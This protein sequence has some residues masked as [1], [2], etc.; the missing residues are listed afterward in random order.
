MSANATGEPHCLQRLDIVP[1]LDSGMV[2]ESQTS[3]LLRD[4]LG[5]HSQEEHSMLSGDTIPIEEFDMSKDMSSS[6]SVDRPAPLYRY[7][8]LASTQTQSLHDDD[9]PQNTLEGSQKENLSASRDALYSSSNQVQ[10]MLVLPSPARPPRDSLVPRS[11]QS[12]AKVTF[13]AFFVESIFK[14]LLGNNKH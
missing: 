9:D 5:S 14:S 10:T 12:P 6:D 8:G 11:K 3:Q 1:T 2:E 7:H 4:A 13:T